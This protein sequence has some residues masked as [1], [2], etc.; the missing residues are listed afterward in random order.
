MAKESTRVREVH[1]R[2]A[3]SLGINISP[4]TILRESD[5]Y[6]KPRLFDE[7]HSIYVERDEPAPKD[8]T[9]ARIVKFRIP[10]ANVALI[11]YGPDK[12]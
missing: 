6:A 3:V 10:M 12:P 2:Q 8:E 7:G 11:V 1:L 5:P 4:A 9:P